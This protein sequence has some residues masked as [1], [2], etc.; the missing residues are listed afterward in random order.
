MAERTLPISDF[1]AK[2][3]DILKQ[4]GEHRLDKVTVT[5]HGRP[6]A[7]VL[8]PPTADEA[9]KAIF[10]S[11]RGQVIIP[12]KVDLTAPTF[13]DEIIAETGELHL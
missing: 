13:D 8:P 11:M 12:A 3:L 2:C 6:V 10:G 4:L 1:K 5:R 9:A 7:I